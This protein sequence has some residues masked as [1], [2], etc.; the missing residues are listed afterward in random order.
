M[1]ARQFLR[2]HAG[3]LLIW[4]AVAVLLTATSALGVTTVAESNPLEALLQALPPGLQ[5][6]AGGDLT[7]MDNPADGYVLMKVLYVPPVLFGIYGVLTA[8]AIVGREQERGTSDFLFA[9]PLRRGHVLLH[10]F[11]AL[12][13]ALALLWLVTWLT[14]VAVMT[15][16][17]QPGSYDRYAIV[18]AG[19]FALNAAQAALALLTGM[20]MREPGVATRWGLAAAIGLFLLNTMLQVVEAPVGWRWLTL[21]G[22]VDGYDIVSTGQ[23]PW[24]GLAVLA[25]LT[26]AA[27]V[28][29]VRRLAARQFA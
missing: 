16:L 12:T 15:A 22:I 21:Y 20:Y 10:R 24:A 1:V 9:L 14:T 6:L 25:A 2:L 5:R 7:G 3:P 26:A 18:A 13:A 11:A 28:L 4:L 29:A 19:G 17:E 23:W 8:A 27:L